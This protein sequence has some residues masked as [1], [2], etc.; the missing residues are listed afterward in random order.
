MR[1]YF[2][3]VSI[4]L[5]IAAMCGAALSWDG[6]YYLYKTLDTQSPFVLHSRLINVALQWPVLVASH[7]TSDIRVLNAVFGLLHASVP[8]IALAASWWIVRER[9]PG[10]FVWAALGICLGTLP[11]LFQLTSD[12]I[13][14]VELFW[15]VLLILVVRIPRRHI[16]VLLCFVAVVFVSHPT[17][18]ALLGFGAVSAGFIGLVSRAERRKM[19]AWAS[20]LG[21][22]AIA[23][24]LMIKDSYEINQLSVPS[25]MRA[26]YLALA[27][28]P[29]AAL[30][31]AWLATLLVLALAVVL[32]N[33]SHKV[34]R[35]V[36]L[37]AFMGV[38]AA[39]ALFV[40]WA[41]NPVS[42]MYAI[43]FRSWALSTAVPFMIAA[44][45]EGTVGWSS[46]ARNAGNLLTFRRRVVEVVG[47]VFLIVLAEQSL[48]FAGLTGELEQA[49]AQ[50]PLPCLSTQSMATLHNTALNNWATPAYAAL[51]QGKAPHK[52]VLDS[53]GCT[54]ARL[55]GDIRLVSFDAQ[56]NGA[57]WFNLRPVRA[58][59]LAPAACWFTL[60]PGWYPPEQ[61]AS[62]WWRWSQGRG[63]IRVFVQRPVQAT[64][65][66]DLTSVMQSNRVDV[67]INGHRIAT[68]ATTKNTFRPFH[69]LILRLT[70]G[71]NVI[72]FQSRAKAIHLAHDSRALAVATRNL[73][74]MTGADFPT[75]SACDLQA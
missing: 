10:L 55:S 61:K 63:R 53:N 12:A 52:L 64:M 65:S 70:K 4:A 71:E 7:F 33:P 34:A 36:Q 41:G 58:H 62:A 57:G 66:G 26:F 35:G 1:I 50:S 51:L 29:L 48:S 31:C 60:S 21:V 25:Q 19:L 27:G 59:L 30:T 74:L 73:E 6:S 8:L 40:M 23:R 56:S 15:P 5:C 69:P 13:D 2:L 22:M 24:F 46:V 18:S 16:P 43:D 28:L 32:K 42:W 68:I 39:G 14:V 11:G 38:G 75:A 49:I 9:A 20:V 67:L 17:A 37:S 44:V 3:L 72:E 54:A 47:W 45:V